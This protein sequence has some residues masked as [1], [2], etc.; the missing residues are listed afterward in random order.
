MTWKTAAAIL[1]ATS[2][3][4]LNAAA[5][6][7]T[8]AGRAA[9]RPGIEATCAA[10]LGTGMKTRRTFCDVLIAAVPAESIAITI[11][12]HAAAAT[13][14][15]DLHN[16]FPVPNVVLSGPLIYQRHEAIVAVVRSTGAVIDRAAVIREFRRVSDLFDQINAGSRPG[17][18][19]SVAPGPP[20]A[21]R[22]TIPAGITSIG[23]VGKSLRISRRAGDETFDAPGRPVAVISN[24]RVDVRR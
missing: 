9:A 17:N 22:I 5:Q 3:V 23:I 7:G 6:R 16:R 10:E 19:R 20:E 21:I 12:A 4:A 13:L 18:V 8:P 14:Q 11:P 1:V 15:F 24:L 2:T